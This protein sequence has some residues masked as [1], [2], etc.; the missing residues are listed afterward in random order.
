MR[1]NILLLFLVL[2]VT[3]IGEKFVAGLCVFTAKHRVYVVSNLPSNTAPLKIHCASGNNDLGNHTLYPNQDYRWSFCVNFIPNTLF[4]CHLWWGSKDKAFEVFRETWTDVPKDQS[5]WIAKSD[6]IYFSDQTKPT[7]L[8]KKYD[9][10][11]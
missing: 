5:W 8:Q 7:K 2:E 10:N 6:G 4:F 1:K 11:N 3:I 9:W